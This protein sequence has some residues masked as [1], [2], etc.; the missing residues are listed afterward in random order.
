MRMRILETSLHMDLPLAHPAFL[1]KHS[2][3]LTALQSSFHSSFT[4]A[5]LHHTCLILSISL[6]CQVPG[7][8]PQD[9]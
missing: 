2:S 8:V 1:E 3:A 6:S 7:A 9:S 4:R 5:S